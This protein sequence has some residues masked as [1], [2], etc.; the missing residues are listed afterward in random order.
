MPHLPIPYRSR[1][2]LCVRSA[3]FTG[4]LAAVPGL[5]VLAAGEPSASREQSRGYAI[6]AGNLDQV[7]NRFASEAGILLSADAQLTAGKRSPGLNG[8][9]GVGEGL[10]RLLAGTGLQAINTGG[11]YALAVA[12]ETGKAVELGATRIQDAGLELQSEGTGAYVSTRPSSSATKLGLSLKETPQSVTVITRQ[13]L[14]DQ[15]LSRITDVLEATVGISTFNQ[16][17]GTDLDQPYSRGFMISN[18]LV[19][20]LPKS[21]SKLF[22]LQASTAMFDRVEVVRGATGLMSGMG[23]PGA[24]INMVRK[25]P[26]AQNQASVSAEAGRW[27]Q[28]GV[29]TDVSGPLN[30]TGTIR[31]RLVLDHKDRN[32]WLDRYESRADLAY[33]ITEFDLSEQTLLSVGFS[34]Q[35]NDNEQPLR[36]GVPLF[37]DNNYSTGTRINLPRSYN[38]AP[39]WSYYDTRQSNL[40]V[41]LDHAFDNGWNG[42]VEISRS[43]NE[44]DA[45]SYYQ[46][47]EIDATTGLGSSI[48]PAKWV[49]TNTVNSL[50]A[51]AT[52]PFSFLG[53]AHELVAGVALSHTDIKSDNYGW[54]YSWNSNYD[55]TL[56]NVW[57]WN[58]RGAN[59]PDFNRTGKTTTEETQYSAYL[60]SRFSLTDATHL[61]IGSRVMDWKRNAR[62]VSTTGV[63]S[64]QDKTESGVVVPFAGLIYD[65]D[66]TWSLYGSYTQIFNPQSATVRDINNS[67][68]EPE[69]GTAYEAGIKAAFNNGRLNANLA[70]FKVEQDNVAEYDGTLSAYRSLQGIT[71]EGVELEAN[72]ELS[73]GWNI[74]GGYA[75]SLSEDA[76]GNRAMSR[77]PRH[78]VKGF[79]T[80]RLSGALHRVTIGGGFNWKS[81]YGFEGEGYPEQGSYMLLSAMTRYDINQNLSATLNASNL[82]DKKYYAS[83]TDNGVYGEPRNLI[84]SLKYSF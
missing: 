8:N 79:T 57:D 24:S 77:I 80:Y 83:I 39:D 44:Q 30:S 9:Y 65:L 73:E 17:I 33:G 38:N 5:P 22:S 59:R 52:G 27:D 64:R 6:P 42:K 40:F 15:K 11:N 69:E 10:A 62:T 56:G 25:R 43:R 82:L 18:Y 12:V 14:D 71:T 68:L 84:L 13:R 23:S 60:T 47:G 7:L 70:L 21:S 49:E 51:Y 19:D 4:L 45:I 74:A 63:R 67:P 46:Y 61:I 78:N 32:S 50:D 81:R 72:G 55:G 54:L 1:L 48:A 20:G 53:R 31:S 2:S 58:G 66:D 16:G 36:S 28:Y 37:Y 3:L 26:T 41:S 34:Y 35:S 76:Q 29:G 75:Y